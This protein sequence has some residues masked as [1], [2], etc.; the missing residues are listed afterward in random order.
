[1]RD[2]GVTVLA[3]DAVGVHDTVEDVVAE[4]HRG[5][6]RLVLGFLN[7]GR[8]LGGCL[9]VFD[10]VAKDR[11]VEGVEEVG[12]DVTLAL[13]HVRDVDAFG[14]S[15]AGQVPDDGGA[16]GVSLLRHLDVVE[17]FLVGANVAPVHLVAGWDDVLELHIGQRRVAVVL[18]EDEHLVAASAA[19]LQRLLSGREVT[20]VVHDTNRRGRL[21]VALADGAEALAAELAADWSVHPLVLR[22][23]VGSH[24]VV[25]HGDLVTWR[26]TDGALAADGQRQGMTGTVW[27]V[28]FPFQRDAFADFR[29]ELLRRQRLTGVLDF[30]GRGVQRV[31]HAGDV[32]GEAHQVDVRGTDVGDL[33]FRLNGLFP[34][35]VEF[36]LAVGLLHLAV[37]HREI[38]GSHRQ[39]AFGRSA[40]ARQ[41]RVGQFP[42]QVWLFGRSDADR[43]RA[44]FAVRSHVFI[45]VA[46]VKQQFVTS[47]QACL[48]LH[49]VNGKGRAVFEHR[50]HFP[51]IGSLALDGAHVGEAPTEGV[52]VFEIHGR[53]GCI[54]A[55]GGHGRTAGDGLLSVR[56]EGASHHEGA[57][58]AGGERANVPRQGTVFDGGV[59]RF[60]DVHACR[61][62]PSD[63]HVMQVRGRDVAHVDFERDGVLRT[64]GQGERTLLVPCWIGVKALGHHE[65]VPV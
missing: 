10:F 45:D 16:R 62:R 48:K 42:G 25:G 38:T 36:R 58:C 3:V 53:K 18:E 63:D 14:L 8:G 34:V 23:G 11:T 20:A 56:A 32:V 6:G 54:G 57:G 27:A 35:G 17:Q 13:D 50:G 52:E 19:D 44:P 49:Q 46:E 5:S 51:G 21:H 30:Q 59:F 47:L 24:Q 43:L 61:K 41:D 9:I 39:G 60:S 28:V 55:V 4:L 2:E 37:D 64:H 1:M 29:L 26:H 15:D 65:H 40:G 12:V 31:E 22:R 33:D 7:L